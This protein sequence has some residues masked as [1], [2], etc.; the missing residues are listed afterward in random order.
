MKL[1]HILGFLALAAAASQAAVSFTPVTEGATGGAQKLYNFLATNYGVKTVSGMMTGDVGS[2]TDVK[3]QVDVDTMHQKTGKYP[4]LVG[5][6]FLFATGKEASSSWY[7]SYTNT[8]LTLAKDL[9]SQGGIPAFTWHW[10]D[11]SDSVDAFYTKSGNATTYT[12]FDYTKGF[13]AG[14]TTWDTT[15]TTYKQLV[16]S[17]DLI[18]AKF[19][20]LQKDS[21]AAIFRPLHEASGGWFWWG[22]HGGASFQALYSLIH[23]RMVNVD[24]VKNLVWVWNPEYATDVAWNPGSTKYDV[25]SMDIYEAYDYTTKFVSGYK[26]LATNY[27]TENKIFAV[28]ENGPIPD[29]SNM[30]KNGTVWSWWMPW[31]QSWSGKFL[32]QTV[33]AV[34]KANM[35]DSCTITLDKMPGWDKYVVSNAPVGSCTVG[36]ALGDLDTARK[37]VEIAPG[38]TAKN[39]WLKVKFNTPADDTAKGNII[40]GTAMD[41]STAKTASVTVYNTNKMS[42]IW[43]TVAFL[44]NENTSWGWAQPDGGTNSGCW[45]N[46]GDSTTCK[47]DLTTLTKDKVLLTG[48]DYRTFMSNISKAYLEIFGQNYS[49]TIFFDKVVVDNSIVLNN[50]DKKAVIKSESAK[51]LAVAEIVGNGSSAGIAAMPGVSGNRISLQGNSVLLTLVQSGNVSVDLFD[52]QGHRTASLYNGNLAAGAHTLAMKNVTQGVYVVRAKGANVSALQK[53][54]V[55]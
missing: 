43:F 49:G 13:K 48:A 22:T 47:I 27:G 9:W 1:A 44:G 15:S 21:V 37:I 4:A 2:G 19:L 5:F 6:D 46:A 38:D 10:K 26:A 41:L 32:D 30:H 17:I 33:D 24:G 51:N 34:W 50:F 40:I 7:Q 45:V 39:G 14:T 31:Y 11:P 18:A 53:V 54:I 35:N 36:Y 55:K 3:A 52:L 16:S 42:G 12:T 25:I 23:D 28:T 29:A 8:A 20:S